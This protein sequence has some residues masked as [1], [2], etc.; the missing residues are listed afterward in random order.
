VVD[1]VLGFTLIPAVQSVRDSFFGDLMTD[2]VKM[3]H[4]ERASLSKKIAALDIAIHE[5]NGTSMNA[6]PV[7]L[8]HKKRVMSAATRAKISAAA[9]KRW[10]KRRR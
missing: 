3:L 4:E 5:L 1:R 7:T 10:A 9:K 6:Q 2:L 8:A